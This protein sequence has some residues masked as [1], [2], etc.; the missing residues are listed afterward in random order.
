[1]DIEE[2]RLDIFR[3]FDLKIDRD[4][5]IWAF[6]YA[7]K[8]I[9]E[10]INSILIETNKSNL[11]SQQEFQENLREQFDEVLNEINSVFTEF[12]RQISLKTTKINFTHSDNKVS[13]T[14]IEDLEN[15][16]SKAQNNL[17]KIILESVE[18]IDIDSFSNEISKKINSDVQTN[19]LRFFEEI[20]KKNLEIQ[21]NI[22]TLNDL[23]FKLEEGIEQLNKKISYSNIITFVQAFLFGMTLSFLGFV[24]FDL[25]N[26]SQNLHDLSFQNF[27][28]FQPYQHQ[29]FN[30]TNNH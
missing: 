3:L 16:V 12:K 14:K 21:K 11:Q 7:N 29:D 20:D 13:S 4:D 2:L 25:S 5:P 19:I 30:Q 1:M 27:R 22:E 15:L 17:E 28:T 10:K 26:K 23:K 9:I 6:L 18:K 8:E 24:Y